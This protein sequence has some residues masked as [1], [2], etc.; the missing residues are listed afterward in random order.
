MTALV[1]GLIIFMGVHSV[2]IVSDDFRTRQIE[3][4]GVN[5]EPIGPG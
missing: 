1:L 3:K 2:R 5:T 4:V